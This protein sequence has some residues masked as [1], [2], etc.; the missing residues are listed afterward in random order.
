M[1]RPTA[2]SPLA[3]AAPRLRRRARCR[4]TSRSAPGTA[5]ASTAV[6][7]CCTRA[8]GRGMYVGWWIWHVDVCG[9]V[10]HARRCPAAVAEGHWA[11]PCPGGGRL[12]LQGPGRPCHAIHTHWPHC[13]CRPAWQSSKC[14]RRESAHNLTPYPSARPSDQAAAARRALPAST[15]RS[16]PAAPA[17]WPTPHC[18]AARRASCRQTARAAP[19]G[20]AWTGRGPAAPLAPWTL[21]ASAAA[22]A[23]LWTSR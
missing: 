9:C 18:S 12:D 1:Q 3:A 11:H 2:P 19:E 8:G 7:A 23:Q 10:W 20:R 4:R 15:A 13:P 22:T 14:G 6:S 16:S 17:G 21:V 5:H